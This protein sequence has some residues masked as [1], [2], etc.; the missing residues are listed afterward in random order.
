MLDQVTEL[1]GIRADADL[2][3]CRDGQPL[4][5][6]VARMLAGV[7]DALERLAPDVVVV[8]GDTATTVA[9]AVA[10]FYRGVPV[11][12]LEAGLRTGDLGSPFPEEG[13]R[14]MVAAIADLHLAPTATAAARLLDENI[15][16]PRVVITGNTVIDALH[17]ALEHP[18][19]EPAELAGLD[20][21]RPLLLLTAHRRESW[22]EPM[23]EIGRALAEIAAAEPHLQIVVPVH[24]NRLV[25]E[26]LLPEVAD[27]ANIEVYDP[28]PY[29]SFCQL[30]A[31]ST[32]V[33]TD[34]GGI[35]EEAPSLGKPVL[36][37]R[38]TTERPEAIAAGTVRLVGTRRQALVG[39]TL[40]LLR[41]PHSYA[42][43]AR[44]VNPYGDGRATERTLAA[45]DHRYLGGPPAED[46]APATAHPRPARLADSIR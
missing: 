13:N 6:M 44:A 1:F 3:I 43:M 2:D 45:L 22:G 15:P 14:R 29:G 8:Q 32:I 39:A 20:P 41:D 4:T 28:L 35:Q 10:A 11:V 27:V 37:L 16:A 24:R 19:P 21:D 42:A 25:R 5:E 31:R 12:H 40:E 34:S 38:D 33:L 26:A 17:L 46:F 36:V 18:E 7:G 9:A 30:L 23:R